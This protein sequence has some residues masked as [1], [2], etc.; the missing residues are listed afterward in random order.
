MIFGSVYSTFMISEKKKIP[1]VRSTTVVLETVSR[2]SI[3]S[4]TVQNCL[5]AIK[6]TLSDW[7]GT[8]GTVYK[9]SHPVL[10]QSTPVTLLLRTA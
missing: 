6:G 5:R 9:S 3:V 10:G 4:K 1:T 8:S 7:Y 2:C